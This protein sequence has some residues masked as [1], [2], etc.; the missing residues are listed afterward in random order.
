[1]KRV[2]LSTLVIVFLFI[3]GCN[4]SIETNLHKTSS[5]SDT[6][7][8]VFI[9]D[10]PSMSTAPPNTP[11]ETTVIE[12]TPSASDNQSEPPSVSNVFDAA[13][14]AYKAVLENKAN[15]YST[16][17]EKSVLLNDFLENKEIIVKTFAIWGFT[18]LDMD[19]D[20]IPEIV[21]DLGPPGLYEVLHYYEGDVYGYMFS[22]RQ[23][24][25][26]KTDGIFRWSSSAFH[27]GY[28]R[29]K[30]ES[31][32][33]I[34]DRIGYVNSMYNDGN[35][36]IE[37]C[38]DNQF[39]TEEEYDS[40]CEI[41]DAKTDAIWY[42][43]SQKSIH[44]ELINDT[45]DF[46]DATIEAITRFILNKPIEDITTIDVKSITELSVDQEDEDG[47]YVNTSA[48]ITTLSDLVNFKNLRNL[49]LFGCQL[50]SLR[51]IENLSQLEVLNLYRT[52]ISDI[53]LL[54]NLSNLID[55]NIG[56]NNIYDLSPLSELIHLEHLNVEGENL[57][58]IPLKN[59]TNLTSLHIVFSGVSDLSPLENLTNIT[60]LNLFHND[61][62]DISVLRN[63]VHLT[64]LEIGLNPV[65]DINVLDELPELTHIS[66]EVS[67]LTEEQLID[68]LYSRHWYYSS[69]EIPMVYVDVSTIGTSDTIF[70][71]MYKI[72][73]SDS[74][75]ISEPFETIFFDSYCAVEEWSE[76]FINFD[77]LNV[78]VKLAGTL[79]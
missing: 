17:N 69:N 79:T 16:E 51:G 63:M 31:A 1:M 4:S 32:E 52:G 60:Y 43:F 19:G 73:I 21:L 34:T 30:F 46:Q 74:E 36:T 75:D 48:P 24:G 20:G 37:Y 13:L 57:D 65:N 68:H 66:V 26:L 18:I 67:N 56:D 38:I 62:S 64:Y 42:D 40:F 8:E 7:S 61:I 2:I 49:D 5:S 9:D 28:G 70:E 47:N 23:L 22:N 14:D 58:L 6:T 71:R 15:F 29:L 54:S 72:E 41:Q 77:D 45:I 76:F 53:S 44:A 78:S 55:L 25:N 3:V 27:N 39:V 12:A 10:T 59:L 33:C 11:S 50:N 35:P